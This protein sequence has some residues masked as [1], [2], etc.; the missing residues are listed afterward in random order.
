M[1]TDKKI[2]DIITKII[3]S[4]DPDRIILFGSYADGTADED[5]DLDLIIIKNTDKPKHK[6]AKEIRRF[7]LGSMI[8]MDL[9]I[10]T[11]SEFENE[12]SSDFSFLN[13]AIK[14]S[15]IVYERDN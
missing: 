5:S 1:I 11:P 9:K 15:V 14:N 4:Y 3:R 6:R 2:T 10:Y 13:S 12:K 7:L 8:P